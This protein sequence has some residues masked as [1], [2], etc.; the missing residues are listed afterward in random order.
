[1]SEYA[2]YTSN[3]RAEITSMR[4]ACGVTTLGGWGMV[5]AMMRWQGE[6]QILEWISGIKW[7]C[8]M[9][10]CSTEVRWGGI[11]WGNGNM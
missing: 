8:H 7:L 6:L 10:R 4:N 2:T 9:I 5:W 1:M 11:Q 3:D